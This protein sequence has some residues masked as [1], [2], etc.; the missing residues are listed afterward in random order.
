MLVVTV[1]STTLARVAYDEARAVLQ[2]EFCSRAVYLYFDVP[3]AVHQ[4][5]LGAASKGRFFNLTIRGRFPYRLISDFP[6]ATPEVGV[7]ADAVARRS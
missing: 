7:R 3:A 1:E 5:L 2:L 4:A 6:N